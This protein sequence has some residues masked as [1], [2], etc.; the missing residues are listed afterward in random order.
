MPL[1][2]LTV[3]GYNQVCKRVRFWLP[4]PPVIYMQILH[5]GLVDSGLSPSSWPTLG[6]Q[7]LQPVACRPEHYTYMTR[8]ASQLKG[9]INVKVYTDWSHSLLVNFPYCLLFH[10]Q[11]FGVRFIYFKM[12]WWIS[13]IYTFKC[14]LKFKR[15]KS[16]PGTASLENPLLDE[17]V[18]CVLRVYVCFCFQYNLAECWEKSKPKLQCLQPATCYWGRNL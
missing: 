9:L 11:Y 10:L 5:R 2:Q 13:V 1:L 4:P 18:L 15:K 14:H 3:N 6:T 16:K 7:H 12:F 8:L 17:S